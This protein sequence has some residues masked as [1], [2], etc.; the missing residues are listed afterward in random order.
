M[1]P[2][3]CDHLDDYG[4]KF[5][6]AKASYNNCLHLIDSMIKDFPQNDLSSTLEGAL[7]EWVR[8]THDLRG[9]FESLVKSG[10]IEI[11][12]AGETELVIKGPSQGPKCTKC[13]FSVPKLTFP[14]FDL[15]DDDNPKYRGQELP[16]MVGVET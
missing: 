7:D 11:L 10:S 5:G 15:S 6:R 12:S 8:E 3:F 14:E 4:V 2:T 1:E 16:T 9:S 13:D